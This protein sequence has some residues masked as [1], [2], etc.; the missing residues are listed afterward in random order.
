[1]SF[2]F[3]ASG[4]FPEVKLIAIVFPCRLLC[5]LRFLL[6]EDRADNTHPL[7]AKADRLSREVIGAALEVQRIVRPGLLAG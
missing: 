2:T 6:F 3:A 4:T 1:M 5:F 7:F